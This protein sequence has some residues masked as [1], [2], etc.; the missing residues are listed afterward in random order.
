MVMSAFRRSVVADT[1]QKGGGRKGSFHDR[2]RLP[3][4]PAPE[5]AGILLRGDYV[6]PSPAP[7]Q[8]EID[9]ATGRPKE[10]RNPYFK[11]RQHKHATKK[12]GKDWFATE[13]CSAG[14]DPYNPQP[15]VGCFAMD[16]GNKA[17]GVSDM[18]AM[19]YIHLA[20]Y[21]GH[22][23]LDGNNQIVMKREKQEPVIV[24]DECVGR[25]C[26]YCRVLNN[27]PVIA[28][29]DDPW[30]GWSPQQITTVFGRRRYLEVGKGHL[31]DLSGIDSVIGSMCGACGSQLTTDGFACTTCNSMVIDMAADTRTDEQIAMEVLKPYPCMRCGRAVMLK[32][33]VSCEV[34]ERQGRQ[35]VQ[36]S[37]FDVVLFAKRQGEGT[38]SHI[39]RTNHM[40]IE[41][42]AQRVD[43]RF[44]NG[45]SLRDYITE[46]AGQPYD[47]PEMFK[48]K[49][50]QDQSKRL[51]LPMPPG[52]GGQMQQQY[53]SYGGPQAPA[54]PPQY[55]APQ[56]PY[57]APPP[58]APQYA[59]QQPYGAPPPQAAP[60]PAP[61]MQSGGM[62]VPQPAPQQY[63][64]Q[65]QPMQQPGPGPQAP[66]PMAPPYFGRQ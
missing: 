40:T 5:A 47:F 27:Q 4:E 66:A 33:V 1:K 49:N 59:P 61:Q 57:G 63:P 10:V 37:L 65:M 11:Y 22:P 24:Y 8:I 56:Q 18:F 16:S 7:E 44:L 55:G 3:A 2:Y 12:N 34:C 43:P 35:G 41:Q 15:C 29:N 58:Q 25:T 36:L 13:I 28:S 39:V 50:L 17:V 38:K 14:I 46:L 20:Y 53:M 62:M 51:E 6:D 45:K 32:E 42:Y 23:L 64:P 19:G 30:P 60:M 48:P 26:N 21:H 52:A 9:P 31:S 54:A